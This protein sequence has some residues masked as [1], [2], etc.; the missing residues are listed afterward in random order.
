MIKKRRLRVEKS[1]PGA[2]HITKEIFIVQIIVTRELSP[3]DSLYLRCL[4]EKKGDAVMVCEGLLNLFGTSSEEIRDEV[5][6]FCQPKIDALTAENEQQSSSINKLSS[7]IN[8]LQ[9][10]LIQNNIP[11]N[12]ES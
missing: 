3:E 9:D 11:F 10:L 8:Y 4:T 12:L 6:A 2:Y 7:Q 1:A 5:A